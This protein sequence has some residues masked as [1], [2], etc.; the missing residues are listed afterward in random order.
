MAGHNARDNADE[1]RKEDYEC[2]V[3]YE[4]QRDQHTWGAGQGN[5]T[6][7]EEWS[8]DH[9]NTGPSRMRNDLAWAKRLLLLLVYAALHHPHVPGP[10]FIRPSSSLVTHPP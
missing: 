4:Q 9:H 6:T 10:P 5:G 2:H 1:E 7:A 3:K 8:N